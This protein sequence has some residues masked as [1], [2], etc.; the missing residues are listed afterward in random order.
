MANPPIASSPTEPD[1]WSPVP[2]GEAFRAQGDDYEATFAGEAVT[3]GPRPPMSPPAGAAAAPASSRQGDRSISLSLRE[4]WQGRS[5]VLLTLPGAAA[6]GPATAAPPRLEEGRIVYDR[7]SALRE[8]YSCLKD[9]VEQSFEIAHP[10][11]D[12]GDLLLVAGLRTQL[13][14]HRQDPGDGPIVFASRT[15]PGCGGV[16][17]YGA[18]VAIDARG[19]REAVLSWTAGDALC[20]SLSGEWLSSAQFPVVVDPRLT[21]KVQI[22]NLSRQVA[23]AY[24]G[25]GGAYEVVFG[26]GGPLQ[27]RR[28]DP[29][30]TPLGA[31]VALGG[32]ASDS[33]RIVASALTGRSL[34]LWVQA[35]GPAAYPGIGFPG[36]IVGVLLAPD[37][38]IERPAFTVATVGAFDGLDAV[39][40]SAPDEFEL[41]WGDTSGISPASGYG[42]ARLWRARLRGDG[43]VLDGGTELLVESNNRA[44]V[45]ALGYDPSNDRTLLLYQRASPL[46]LRVLGTNTE[47]SGNWQ[48]SLAWNSE[49]RNFGL[50]AKNSQSGYPFFAAL[51]PT[52][53]L[54]SQG[55]EVGGGIVSPGPL[56]FAPAANRFAFLHWG[57]MSSWLTELGADGRA[58]ARMRVGDKWAFYVRG[59]A[60]A[61]DPGRQRFLAVAND[62]GALRSQLFTL[63][64]TYA[65][66]AI[67][68]VV[69][70]AG[71]GSVSLTWPGSTSPDVK[72]YW[73]AKSDS[74]T[75]TFV[76][77]HA[78]GLETPAFVDSG[79]AAGI[80]VW[81]RIVVEDRSGNL[82][83][84]SAAVAAIA[85][86][87]AG[88]P[89]L[90][91]LTA[92]SLNR[93]VH[94]TWSPVPAE[95][96]VAC[97]VY[98]KPAGGALAAVALIQAPAASAT[99][100]GL[101]NGTEYAF[102]VSQLDLAGREGPRLVEATA[103][104][105]DHEA[106]GLALDVVAAGVNFGIA[107]SWRKGPEDDVPG[108][109]LYA[110]ATP[111]GEWTLRNPTALLTQTAYLD[112]GV[113]PGV[114]RAFRVSQ[115]DAAGNE[116]PLSAVVEATALDLPPPA[117]GRPSVAAGNRRAV[118]Q[119]APIA[120]V[121]DVVGHRVYRTSQPGSAGVLVSGVAPIAGS[122]WTDE[123]LTN[124]V[125]YGWTTTAV[126]A[127]GQEGPGSAEAA[128][129]PRYP[130][131]TGMRVTAVAPERVALAWNPLVEL[132]VDRYSV[133]RAPAGG[134][135]WVILTPTGVTEPSFVDEG[136][137]PGEYSYAVIAIATGG[138]ESLRSDPVRAWP[139]VVPPPVLDPGTGASGADNT[140]LLSGG[141]L[142]GARVRIF[143]VDFECALATADEHGRFSV[144]V[145]AVRADGVHAFRAVQ[146]PAG[147]GRSTSALSAEVAV[148]VDT[149]PAGVR[150]QA[151]Q[152]LIS[153]TWARNPASALKYHVYRG[154][155]NS[156][157][158]VRV[159][160][161]P[162][163]GT[164]FRDAGLPA[165]T[166][167]YR[168]SAVNVAGGESAPSE[169][170]QAVLDL[171]PPSLL[172]VTP[173]DGAPD[174]GVDAAIV[175]EF[176]EP[177]L[178]STANYGQGLFL[179]DAGRARVVDATVS[180]EGST[181][182]VRSSAPLDHGSVYQV[183]VSAGITDLTG[184]PLVPPAPQLSQ[185]RTAVL[186]LG[187]Y[188]GVGPELDGVWWDD[189][190]TNMALHPTSTWTL[191]F[192]RPLDAETVTADSVLLTY[193]VPGE[194]AAPVATRLEP[195]PDDRTVKVTPLE[196]IP[197]S[198]PATVR[199]K[200]SVKDRAGHGMLWIPGGEER[201]A[202]FANS[203][204]ADP[205]APRVLWSRPADRTEGVRTDAPIR[206]RFS[207]LMDA[208]SVTSATVNVSQ[209]GAPVAGTVTLDD[210]RREVTFRP[211]ID[212]SPETEFEV[213]VTTV[214]DHSGLAL[215]QDA[216]VEGDQPFVARF[217]TG[218]ADAE[219]PF[220]VG[221]GPVC[222][223]SGVFP[224]ELPALV[225]SEPVDPA[226]LPAAGLS[227]T[228]DGAAVAGEW[229]R[230]DEAGGGVLRFAP[231]EPIA[232][233]AVV[234]L[235]VAPAGGPRDLA[236]T[237]FNQTPGYE[238]A[239][240]FQSGY[241]LVTEDELVPQVEFVSPAAWTNVS[242]P[243]I[244]ARV[245]VPGG[246]VDECTLEATV[247]GEAAQQ[248]AAGPGS[249]ATV[250]FYP[251]AFF[252]EGAAYT[253]RLAVAD[254]RGRHGEATRTVR[255]ET[256]PP[257]ITAKYPPADRPVTPTPTLGVT[258]ADDLSGIDPGRVTFSLDAGPEVPAS[259]ATAAEA[260]L[261]IVT[262]LAAGAHTAW[263]HVR[264]HAGNV[265]SEEFSPLY[266]DTET[267]W[268]EP[269]EPAPSSIL[270]RI[271]DVRV[272]YGDDYS[273]DRATVALLVDGADVTATPGT[274]I[275]DAF[276]L[277]HLPADLA[278]GQHTLTFRAADWVGNRA[279][280]TWQFT[281]DS[282]SP[283]ATLVSPA[284]GSTVSSV[285]P[286]LQIEFS[287]GSGGSGIDPT[288]IALYAGG[289]T[290]GW[291]LTGSTLTFTPE[292]DLPTGD[293]PL[294]VL[295]RDVAGNAARAEWRI[296][297]DPA[298]TGGTPAP[299]L[300]ILAPDNGELVRTA[301]P[302]I[303]LAFAPSADP[304][305]RASLLL[306]VDPFG[307][308]PLDLSLAATD[309]LAGAHATVPSTTPLALG[310]HS[311]QA[312]IADTA[313]RRAV[314]FVEFDVDPRGPQ[315]TIAAPP[316][317]S[318]VL[319]PR[320][321]L[322]IR[323]A[324]RGV[325][326][327][328]ASLRVL[329]DPHAAAPQDVSAFAG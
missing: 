273:V 144:E 25:S 42:T 102:A 239:A 106:P 245:S 11:A 133:E 158:V 181:A 142:A 174:V 54:L 232:F 109:R 313:G 240:S 8:V 242:Y 52:G 292:A 16:L 224:W 97:R 100:D 90:E 303:E 156:A 39:W 250:T 132:D 301:T 134:G 298:G 320:P 235:A 173:A 131:P 230:D 78:V 163:T 178:L 53:T 309:T 321:I 72:A 241:R 176:S 117:P 226:S 68:D 99:I 108:F 4:V 21:T 1:P 44:T 85:F 115:V 13:V 84:P 22:G 225:F 38:S 302:T 192:T 187:V 119:L 300:T 194:A 40:C 136:V 234:E 145:G 291:T 171:T 162:V 255:F 69:A 91:S 322:S 222:R 71:S 150:V 274:T 2:A 228:A 92:T 265:A 35:T 14:P 51:S 138:D 315:L 7:G 161:A 319:I 209:D 297:V 279:E 214:R 328:R 299:S 141:A 186:D 204:V 167:R 155:Q 83:L 23:A 168:V 80:P 280:R 125:E 238:P 56:L 175:L 307:D 61:E 296:R 107:I 37:G 202:T 314:A 103:T 199:V 188:E 208:A 306:V 217:R 151:K 166:Y 244:E 264:D 3:F 64:D 277:H 147:L 233:G 88:P 24:T 50:V 311:V 157:D 89:A 261:A 58:A 227:V 116:G 207:K 124:G 259:T 253:L 93:G 231:E 45:R 111:E 203:V 63:T 86:D 213:R 271:P 12:D 143:E 36:V 81:Y 148:T 287:D 123:G 272:M 129:T 183:A 120:G 20:L 282:L 251:T 182:T 79:V 294:E 211:D 268:L 15:S 114:T 27:A 127:L 73:V 87:G 206:L 135:A 325:A 190:P 177:I 256:A 276:V 70:V 243:R 267:P 195:G 5:R 293:Q 180:W 290:S 283:T 327:D 31:P 219:G 285:R 74:A 185:F 6:G 82:S 200:A 98:A 191:H 266:V 19:S 60:L 66:P 329:L 29:D 169:E 316:A 254:P 32:G 193:A 137:P 275:D 95:G 76:R 262:P 318:V 17:S 112:S 284:A 215:D 59:I 257:R 198:A 130:S 62:A 221:A 67:Q 9:G 247:N 196:P 223:G 170:V 48:A 278:Q 324:D 55:G 312:Q 216:A 18:A 218:P 310:R 189:E 246:S 260:T 229:L 140:P 105:A 270:T 305:D 205:R 159:T 220:V 41:V 164:V 28:L 281:Y 33:P 139:E 210:T 308:A 57:Y 160:S 317:G 47:W 34:A 30:G 323:F 184:N 65:P 94:L 128:A 252:A 101:T 154:D 149:T 152:G 269:L 122:T 153:V 46:A 75:G 121:E 179:V 96:I 295:F 289:W 104:P 146:T 126:D 258:F 113:A 77:A 236:G 288:S 197:V 10:L 263:V 26:N 326:I 201:D 237:C 286:T 118:L 304:V 212:W 49:A 43:T 249:S 248:V 172:S 110:R 165:G